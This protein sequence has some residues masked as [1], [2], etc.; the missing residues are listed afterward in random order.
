MMTHELTAA[1]LAGLL[2]GLLG[3]FFFGGLWWTV[4]RGMA[5]PNPALW[6]LTSLTLRMGIALTGFYV[7]GGGY[8]Q[9]LLACLCGFFLARLLVTRLTH[10]ALNKP[11]PPLLEP[12]PDR[13]KNHAP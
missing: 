8:W 7:V 6:F 1:L 11:V 4:Q 3:L 5:S 2:G 13:E 12:L 10:T 9:R